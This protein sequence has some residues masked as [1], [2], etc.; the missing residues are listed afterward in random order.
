MA[1]AETKEAH[2]PGPW[3]TDYR[4]TS[5]GGYS[6]EIF[7][8]AGEVIATAAWFP[9]RLSDTHTTTNREANARLIAAAPTMLEALKALADCSLTDEDGLYEA[10]QLARAA[11]TRAEA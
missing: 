2:T 9:V 4:K 10:K 11:I 8:G 3:H 5:R 7:D 6:Q 1:E